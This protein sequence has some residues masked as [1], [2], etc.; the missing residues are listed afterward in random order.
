MPILNKMLKYV[1]ASGQ[2]LPAQNIQYFGHQR[3]DT[4]H[5]I[6]GLKYIDKI[7]NIGHVVLP[8][9]Q[10]VVSMDG[11]KSVHLHLLVKA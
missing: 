1:C 6:K 11:L 4:C 8:V 3:M 7:E 5:H 10:T 9:L 2:K